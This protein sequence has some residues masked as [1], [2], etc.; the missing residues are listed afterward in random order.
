M[1][2]LGGLVAGLRDLVEL[3]RRG[4]VGAALL[5]HRHPARV[6]GAGCRHRLPQRFAAGQPRRAGDP[7]PV[8]LDRLR[9]PRPGRVLARHM[10]RQLLPIRLPVPLHARVQL[11]VV[12]LRQQAHPPS[13]A[14]GD[15]ALLRLRAPLARRSPRRAHGQTDR[16]RPPPPRLDLLTPTPAPRAPRLDHRDF[17]ENV[18]TAQVDRAISPKSRRSSP[19]GGARGGLGSTLLA[20]KGRQGPTGARREQRTVSTTGLRQRKAGLQRRK[21]DLRQKWPAAKTKKAAAR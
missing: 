14:T 2:F 13:L 17:R 21:I 5:P 8:H 16:R 11:A 19:Q 15:P 4:L 20:G 10:F 9:Q 18:A 7:H 3:V 1:L 6:A 12:P